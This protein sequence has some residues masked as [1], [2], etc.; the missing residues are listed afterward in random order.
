MINAAHEGDLRTVK[1]LQNELSV[2]VDGTKFAKAADA[3]M[4]TFLDFRDPRFH[5]T[6]VFESAAEDRLEV[7]RMLHQLR[8]DLDKPNKEMGATP[9]TIAAQEGHRAMVQL[10]YDLGADVHRARNNGAR[11][12]HAAAVEGRNGT[13]FLLLSLRA[14]TDQIDGI[15]RT[16]LIYAAIA[17]YTSC[18]RVLCEIRSDVHYVSKEGGTAAQYAIQIGGKMLNETLAVLKEYGA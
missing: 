1:R 12:I 16:P 13:L 3:A 17:G 18:V 8:A 14:S 5:G 4:R 6:A 7:V 9:S 11:P 2:A 15:G 10:L